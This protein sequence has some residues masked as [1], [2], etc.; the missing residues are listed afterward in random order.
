MWK[1]ALVM[2]GLAPEQLLESYDIERTFAADENILNSTR[3]TDFITPK[4]AT[5]LMFR[6]A[7]LELARHHPFARKL[8]N[9]GRLSVPSFITNSPL[10]TPD[11]ADFAGQMLPGAPMDDAPMQLNGKDTW[12]LDHLGHRF[13]CLL[14]VDNVSQLTPEVMHIITALAQASV[15]VEPL[16]VCAQAGVLEGVLAAA[17][18]SITL[19]HDVQGLFAKRYDAQTLSAWLSRPDQHV[20]ARWRELSLAQLREALERALAKR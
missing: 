17:H 6:N 20:C 12:L 5:S 7:A 10:N 15:P 3:S 11:V 18:Q 9:S 19:L 14:Y 13:Q 4:S 16:I 1:L 8:V 2:K